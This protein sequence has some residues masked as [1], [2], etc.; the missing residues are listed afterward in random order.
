MDNV[1]LASRWTS[2][3]IDFCTLRTPLR[4]MKACFLILALLGCVAVAKAQ[5]SG[6]VRPNPETKPGARPFSTEPSGADRCVY[7]HPAEVQGFARS[8]MA[9]A[10][11]RSGKEPDGSV[12]AHGSTITMHSSPDRV[13]ANL[14][15]RRR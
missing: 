2:R 3:T 9:R 10:L 1:R 11:R 13:L 12:I 7:C 8:A 14:G 5:V 6:N 4:G 15:K